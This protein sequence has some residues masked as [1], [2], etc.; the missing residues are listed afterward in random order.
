MYAV[1]HCTSPLGLL[2]LGTDASGEKLAGLWIEGQNYFGSTLPGDAVPGEELP[3]FLRARE[4]L[5]R[6]FAGERPAPAELPLA[7]EGSSFRQEVWRRMQAIPYGQVTSYGE[8]ARQMGR[9]SGSGQAIG[10]AVAHNPISIIIP[11]HRVLGAKGALTGY[12]GG[13]ERKKW[14]LA[15]EGA[16]L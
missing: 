13:L 5:E 12:A 11:C 14:L 15:H 16:R 4:W 9:P 3:I 8:I 2:T 1:G 10:G 7:P 6:Y